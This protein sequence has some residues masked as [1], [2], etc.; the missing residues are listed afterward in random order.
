MTIRAT[1][2]PAMDISSSRADQS[3]ASIGGVLTEEGGRHGPIQETPKQFNH[4]LV[5]LGS[6]AL[7]ILR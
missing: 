1:F 6:D 5:K 4:D 2:Q 7:L 3:G